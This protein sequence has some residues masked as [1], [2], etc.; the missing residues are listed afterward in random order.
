M[1]HVAGWGGR[2]A[3]VVTLASCGSTPSGGGQ[4]PSTV[5]AQ[6]AECHSSLS[7]E[8]GSDTQHWCAT[9]AACNGSQWNVATPG[10]TCGMHPDTC[11]ATYASVVRGSTCPTSGIMIC[12]YD[13]GRC[14]CAP[15][16][17]PT[18]GV[19]SPV[20]WT[21]RAWASGGNGCPPVAPLAGTACATPNQ[22]CSYDN[23]CGVRV[24]LNYKCD[25]GAWRVP[26]DPAP[27]DMSMCGAASM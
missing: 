10:N 16:R 1:T 23:L 22:L 26:P 7:C 9:L 2:V 5:P 13:E 18:S 19:I 14:A 3:L 20:E 8:Y 11:P 24:G 21:C 4:C 27:C 25:G 6:G 15:C 12:D 17:T